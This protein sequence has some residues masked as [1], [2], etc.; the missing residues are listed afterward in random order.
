MY[1]VTMLTHFTFGR[2]HHLHTISNL[3]EQMPQCHEQIF[4]NHTTTRH[5]IHWVPGAMYEHLQIIIT[6]TKNIWNFNLNFGCRLSEIKQRK[7]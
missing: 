6:H 4:C 5:R 2:K 1:F 3:V 7:A